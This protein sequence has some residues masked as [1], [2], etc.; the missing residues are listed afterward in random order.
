[1]DPDPDPQLWLTV[2]C[3]VPSNVEVAQ[4]GVL[5][6]ELAHPLTLPHTFV[7]DTPLGT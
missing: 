1:V 6:L 2:T 7:I 3:L 4:L 5:L